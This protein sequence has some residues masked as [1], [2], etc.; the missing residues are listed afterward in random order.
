MIVLDGGTPLKVTAQG[1]IEDELFSHIT[2]LQDG[3]ASVRTL[4]KL[5]LICNSNP[6]LNPDDPPE[7][8]LAT[9][10]NSLS[11]T[12]AVSSDIWDGGRAFDTLVTALL[13]FLRTSTV[14]RFSFRSMFSSA[15]TILMYQ[16]DDTIEYGLCVIWEMVENQTIFLDE[17]EIFSFLFF[18]RYTNTHAVSLSTFD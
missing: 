5:I 4:Q 8:P 7:S 6:A 15:D 9:R 13:A 11:T 14:S 2:S 10:H 17:N 1:A 18:I 16:D 3:T 12:A